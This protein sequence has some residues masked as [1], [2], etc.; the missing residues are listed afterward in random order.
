M[1]EIPLFKYTGA[2]RKLSNWLARHAAL[3]PYTA[4]LVGIGPILTAPFRVLPNF[5]VLGIHKSGTTTLFQNL[6]KHPNILGPENKEVHYFNT[7]YGS[8]LWYKAHFPTKKQVENMILRDGICRV[9]EATPDYLFHPMVPQR[10]KEILPNIKF[11]VVLRNPIDRAFSHYN[12]SLRRKKETLSFK[13]AVTMRKRELGKA[14]QLVREN[15]LQAGRYLEE[16]SYLEKGKY[17]EQL[18][19][20]FKLFPKENFFIFQTSDFN[21]YTWKKIYEFLDLP[22]YKIEIEIKH[23]GC[24]EPIDDE[25]RNWLREYYEPYNRK[26]ENLLNMNFNWK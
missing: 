5:L 7:Y 18:E 12:K 20:W 23:K 24:Y 1:P 10:V 4:S 15:D 21:N 3:N 6:Q 2:R 19:R 8:T 25:T 14:E 26:L 13:E 17:F 9:G 11:L 16:Y 22:D